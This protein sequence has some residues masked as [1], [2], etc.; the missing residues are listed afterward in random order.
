MG[1][2]HGNYKALRNGSNTRYCYDKARTESFLMSIHAP[3]IQ[4]LQLHL[5]IF[6]MDFKV[7]E[8]AG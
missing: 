4:N 2:Q 6:A 7:E 3:L 5:R 8:V 1:A